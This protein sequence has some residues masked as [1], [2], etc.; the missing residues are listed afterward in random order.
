MAGGEA[1]EGEG[2]RRCVP[3][4]LPGARRRPLSLLQRPKAP[5][6]HH[7]HGRPAG[8]QWGAGNAFP[9]PGSRNVHLRP[10]DGRRPGDSGVPGQRGGQEGEREGG[11]TKRQRGGGEAEKL[12]AQ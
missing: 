1:P 2:K 7:P 3:P 11:A 8:C 10:R 5:T 4:A 9:C 6:G 12:R